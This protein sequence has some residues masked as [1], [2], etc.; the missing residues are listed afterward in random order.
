MNIYGVNA[1]KMCFLLCLY[2]HF[3]KAMQFGFNKFQDIQ[4]NSPMFCFPFIV[5]YQK[6]FLQHYCILIILKQWS[7]HCVF[8]RSNFFYLNPSCNSVFRTEFNCEVNSC[9]AVFITN[10][11][12]VPNIHF[13]HRKHHYYIRI[14][15]CQI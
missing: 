7:Q 2:F 10:W 14:I 3:T 11:Q 1:T 8:L 5:F 9:C 4:I 6:G 12:I 15:Y 13:T